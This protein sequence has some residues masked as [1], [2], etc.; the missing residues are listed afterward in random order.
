MCGRTGKRPDIDPVR[1]RGG[2]SDR[3]AA[4]RNGGDNCAGDGRRRW[5]RGF[6]PHL[7]RPLPSRTPDR[8]GAFPAGLPLRRAGTSQPRVGAARTRVGAPGRVRRRSPSC[9][10]TTTSTCGFAEGGDAARRKSACQA[11][12]HGS[13][14]GR[15][16]RSASTAHRID[17][18][19]RS[20]ARATT[21]AGVVRSGAGAAM[22][23]RHR[24]DEST[25][26]GATRIEQRCQFDLR[27][28]SEAV[29]WSSTSR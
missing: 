7:G 13:P 12:G 20:G 4:L 22:G 6:H 2:R 26:D 27:N 29:S 17:G 1:F 9:T 11:A 5:S 19:P 23:R 8:C 16:G 28:A 10:T 25:L 3:R 21:A 18:R 14:T 24:N 15:R